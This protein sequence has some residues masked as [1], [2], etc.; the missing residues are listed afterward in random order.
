MNGGELVADVLL[1]H[2]VRFLF[3]L[4]GGHISPIL[5]AAKKQG[6]R[7]IDCRDEANAVFAAD[8]VARLTGIPGVAAV[9]AGPGVT[10]A[11]TAIQNARMAES[12]VVLLGGATATVLK[13]RGSLQDVD[14]MAMMK[15]LVKSTSTAKTVRGLVSKLEGAFRTA[16]SGV[17][18]PTFVECPVDLLYDEKTVREW[19]AKEGGGKGDDLASKAIQL[20]LKQHLFRQFLGVEELRATVPAAVDVPEPSG[21]DVDKVLA[22]IAKAERPVLVIGSQTLLQ[23]READ[24]IAAAVEKLGM[25]VFLG[26]MARGLLGQSAIQFRHARGKALKAADLVIVCGF[27]LD[28]RMGYGQGIN[29]KA[30]L[31]TVNRDAHAVSKNRSPTLG[32]VADAGRLLQAL[33]GR[34]VPTE[35]RWSAWFETLRT[36]EAARDAEID[37]QAKLP[38]DGFVNPVRLA[39]AID[40]AVAPDSVFVVDGGDFVATLAYVVHP[41]RP[42]SWLDPGVFGTL[43]VG[44]GFAL[45]AGL[46]RPGA[47]IWLIYGDGAAGYSLAEMDTFAR[48]GIP[49]IAVIG[50]NGSWQQIARDQVE[51]LG[52]DVGTVLR[53]TDYHIVADGYGAKGLLLDSNDRIDEVIAEAKRLAAAGHPVV[54]NAQIKDT[55]FRKG[56]ISM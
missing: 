1:Q 9:T 16:A 14:Q 30:T 5:V 31:V 45:A 44:A 48:H 33:G 29:R 21:R 37:E 36:S 39:K 32:I 19:Y 46:C 50:N 35:G 40:G 6:I 11:I 2:G 53:R 54:I 10:N 51:I 28:F 24:R 3:T 23:A 13:G 12:P 25:P 7:I 49:V 42:L 55:D 47:E 8:A 18:G 17:P 56:S 26:G 41:R 34:Y 20:Y 4:C 43:G 22:M 52:D 38:V 27:P 15:P